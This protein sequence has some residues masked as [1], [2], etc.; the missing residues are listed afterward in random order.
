M[1][2]QK[3][4]AMAEMLYVREGKSFQQVAALLGT[5]TMTV[6]RWAREGNWKERRRERRRESPQ[7]SL[8]ALKRQRDLLIKGLDG[9]ALDNPVAINALSKLNLAIQRMESPPEP[10]EMMLDV[11]GRFAEFIAAR[12]DDNEC[13]VMRKWVEK[14]LDEERRRN[15]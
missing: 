8:D 2:P 3:D 9:K 6:C 11:I 13:A 4:R 1:R 15:L 14:F 5:G 10:I 12:A 7:A